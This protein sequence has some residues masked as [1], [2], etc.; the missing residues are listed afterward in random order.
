MANL[1]TSI[2]KPGD[3]VVTGM[4]VWIIRVLI[5]IQAV[6][7]GNAKYRK[8]GHIIVVTHTDSEGRLWGIEG[9][10]GGIGWAQLD[11]RNGSWGMSN[12][13]QPKT[14]DQRAK[15]VNVMKEL[16]G[17][18]YDYG[19]YVAIALN[20]IGINTNW[21]D[22]KGDDVPVHFIC[23]AIADYVYEDVG[24]ENPGGLKITRFTTP[25]EWAAFIGGTEWTVLKP[26]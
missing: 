13:D 7:T 11:K 10:P 3:V 25:A 17:S 26:L 18:K 1:D 12:V 24:L 14:D 15:I 6:L 20:T 16:L 22:F 9:R 5:W 19:A 8:G 23:S 2:L 21:T 4:G